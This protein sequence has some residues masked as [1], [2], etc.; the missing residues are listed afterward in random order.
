M[1][2]SNR[3]IGC[4]SVLLCL[5]TTEEDTPPDLPRIAVTPTPANGIERPSQIMVEKI[6]AARVSKCGKIV[7]QLEPEVMERVDAALVLVM[8]LAD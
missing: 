5:L 7:G 6:I 4:D 2:Q 8:G 3:L 1:I